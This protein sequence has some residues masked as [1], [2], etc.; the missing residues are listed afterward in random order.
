MNKFFNVCI[1][2]VA[3][4][5]L[6]VGVTGCT[7]NADI[8]DGMSNE[9]NTFKYALTEEAGTYRLHTIQKWTDSESDAV[10]ITCS[11]CNNRLW[12]SFN[13]SVLYKEF[14]EYLPEDV[15]ICGG[16]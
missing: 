6:M 12:T 9:T 1:L 11:C 13:T 10:G 2:G 14:P 4:L 7:G 16:E 8:F 5:M 15:T 3:T